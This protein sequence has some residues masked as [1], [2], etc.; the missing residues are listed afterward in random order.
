MLHLKIMKLSYILLTLNLFGAL[1]ANSQDT[2]VLRNIKNITCMSIDAKGNK[3]LSDDA[4][5]L[6]KYSSDHKLITNVNNK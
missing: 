6:Y 4:H 5:T 2:L 1:L 3:Y